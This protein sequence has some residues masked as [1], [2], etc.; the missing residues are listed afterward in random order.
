KTQA[1]K[2]ETETLKGRLIYI[3]N[4][5]TRR[6]RW[7]WLENKTKIDRRHWTGIVTGTS[8]GYAE[9]IEGILKAFPEYAEWII[10]G[11]GEPPPERI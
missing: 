8:K 1:Q 4:A 7:T 10:F 3:L 5:M 6:D 2:Y 11:T 9:D